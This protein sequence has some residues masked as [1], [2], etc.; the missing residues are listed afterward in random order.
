MLKKLTLLGLL[1]ILLYNPL[2]AQYGRTVDRTGGYARV[3]S[4]GASPYITDPYFISA[5]PAWSAKYSN[6]VHGDIGSSTGDDFGPGGDGQY[7][8]A[9]FRLNSKLTLGGYIVRDDFNGMGI[10][11]LDPFDI[12][13]QINDVAG[14]LGVT[15]LDNNMVLLGAYSQGSHVFGFGFSYASTL[16]EDNL[17]NGNTFRS[18][19]SQFGV[20]A[21]YLGRLNNNLTLDAS[22]NLVFPSA[23]VEEPNV[24][25]TE[26]SETIIDINARMFFNFSQKFTLVPLFRLLNSSG[27]AKVGD[28]DGVTN[29]DLTS[30]SNLTVGVGFVYTLSDFLFTGGLL[31]DS[32]G[33]TDPEVPGVSPDLTSS[34]SSFPVWN[35]G[36]EYYVLDWMAARAGYFVGSSTVTTETQSGQTEKDERIRSAFFP[37]NGGYTLGLG[38]RFDGFSLDA[39]VNEDVLRQGLNNIGG[40]GATFAYI[41]VSYAF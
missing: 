4:L 8:G 10:G 24:N 38:F 16:N 13:D 28:A 5:N 11:N 2:F 31:Y 3:Q 41:S 36:A 6:F 23:T 21:G 18:S 7:L 39:T 33:S 15:E 25:D 19:A 32:F 22:L 20:Q 12:V 27:T 37:A 14:G 1:M 30:Y 17:A 26:F 34:V 40:G 9:N 35:L 29:T